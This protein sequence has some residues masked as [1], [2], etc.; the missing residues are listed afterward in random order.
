M[1]WLDG[2]TDSMDMNFNKLLEMV[3]DRKHGLLN[4]I[5]NFKIYV[6]FYISISKIVSFHH[7]RY[8]SIM[9]LTK[10]WLSR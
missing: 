3:K 8:S 9:F 10:E 4:T 7:F 6:Y 5:S 2:I 1:R